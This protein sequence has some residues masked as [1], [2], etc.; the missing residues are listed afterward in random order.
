MVVW[1]LQ[2]V[3]IWEIW[4]KSIQDFFVLVLQP[5]YKTEI[6]SRWIFFF[7]SPSWS[8]ESCPR[9]LHPPSI[10]ERPFTSHRLSQFYLETSMR[11]F[12]RRSHVQGLEGRKEFESEAQGPH[13]VESAWWR[14]LKCHLVLPPT[15]LCLLLP[16]YST[17]Q[18][19]F[20]PIGRIYR[21]KRKKKK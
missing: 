3:S 20:N 21:E 15:P 1:F 2:D 7:L 8:Y 4:V 17:S 19:A 13:C 5:F 11:G 9:P 18:T 12:R 10:S 6:I 14:L 16:P